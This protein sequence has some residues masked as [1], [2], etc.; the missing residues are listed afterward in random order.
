M[1]GPMN[2]PPMDPLSVLMVRDA[3]KARQLQQRVA[4]R[5]ARRQPHTRDLE[6]LEAHLAA[7]A[8]RVIA[9]AGV[10]PA[11]SYPEELPVAQRREDILAA[12]QAHQVVIICGE[13]GSGKTTQLPK[14]CMEAGSGLRGLIGHT[15]PRRIAARTSGPRPRFPERSRYR[16]RAASQAVRP[17]R[18]RVSS[19]A[20]RRV[21]LT[22]RRA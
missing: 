11:V 4:E 10:I 7:S 12:L 3:R 18:W 2:K 17:A 5:Q 22:R 14:L 6:L 21:A 19:R 1:S 13:T 9:R 15:Q 8:E 16:C 20:R